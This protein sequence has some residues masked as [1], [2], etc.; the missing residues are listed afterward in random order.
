MTLKGLQVL[1]I[2]FQ[3]S[4][5]MEEYGKWAMVSKAFFKE[6]KKFSVHIKVYF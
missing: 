4:D 3:D 1:S 5:L 2:R 6:K